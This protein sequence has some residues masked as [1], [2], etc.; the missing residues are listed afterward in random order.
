MKRKRIYSLLLVGLLLLPAC[1][2]V[3]PKEVRKAAVEADFQELRNNTQSYVGKTAILG[4]YILKTENLADH[5]VILVL[6]TPLAYGYEPKSRDLSEGRFMVINEGFLDPEIYEEWRAITVAGEILGKE[7]VLVGNYSYPML[8]IS[9]RNIR[10]WSEP[11]YYYDP[12]YYDPFY[13]WP[14]PYYRYRMG[15]YPYHW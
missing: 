1:A 7:N 5:S 4:G 12:Y 8:K 15:Y 10:L 6:Q 9:A 13:P 14:G 2:S 11:D 3:F